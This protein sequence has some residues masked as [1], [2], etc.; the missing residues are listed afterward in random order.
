MIVSLMFSAIIYRFMTL[1]LDRFER[2][3]RIHILEQ[4]QEGE[5]P[6]MP[7]GEQRLRKLLE[8][9]A[10]VK[11]TKNRILL[12]LGILNMGIL[13]VAGVSGYFLAGRTLK[14]IQEMSDAQNRF[15]S[16]ASHEIKTPLTSLKTAFEVFLRSSTKTVTEAE[17]VIRDSISEVD[18]LH[19]LSKNLL[20]LAHFD[21]PNQIPQKKIVSVEMIIEQALK[22]IK[23]LAKDKK[24]TIQKEL[25]DF[26]IQVNEESMIDLFVI[27]LENAV[28]YSPKKSTITVKATKKGSQG[29]ISVQDT[30]MGIDE[31]DLPHIFDRF[32][33]SDKARTT[34]GKNGYGLG[35]SIAQKI[36]R[37][38]QVQI[39]VTSKVNEGST[40]KLTLPLS[41]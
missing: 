16:D 12:S 5:L 36:A 25:Q 18:K 29:I 26:S 30:G 13:I 15:I 37:M 7:M 9:P 28:K 32:Y 39:A 33:R 21:Q 2:A 20:T 4:L 40:F 35:L 31:N 22:N 17:E 27:I 41:G 23:Y 6:P 8:D 19:H 11:E 34:L 38:Q 10:L 3:R 14:P 24:I 1:E